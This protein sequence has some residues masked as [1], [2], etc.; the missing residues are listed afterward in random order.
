MLEDELRMNESLCDDLGFQVQPCIQCT[1]MMP[2]ESFLSV[3]RESHS[4][5]I[6][7]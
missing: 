5:S 6:V 7:T 4:V 2:S 3:A 1:Y